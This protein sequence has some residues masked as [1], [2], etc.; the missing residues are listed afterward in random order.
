MT[1]HVFD[2]HVDTLLA[3]RN[4]DDFITGSASTQL[5]MPRAREAGVLTLVTAVCAEAAAENMMKAFAIGLDRF[6]I[7][8]G[9]DGL[10]I[11]LMLEGCEPLEHVEDRSSI[12][13][14]LAVASL[15]WNGENA[16]GG[17]IG[18]D[19]CLTEKGIVLAKE[20]H[21]NGVVLD[22]SHLCD[23]SR[24]QL[25]DT[26]LPVVATHCNCRAL[27]SDQRNLP[28]IDLKRI[29]ELGGVTGITLV[30]DFLGPSAD[31]NTVADHLEHAMVV[32]GDMHVGI[33]SDLDGTRDLPEG[34]HDCTFWPEFFEL[35]LIR[36]WKDSTIR[37][38]ADSNWRRVIP[39]AVQN[40]GGD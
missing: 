9:K 17:G 26:G 25:L 4:T 40:N 38:V 23:R 35:L 29:A 20:L 12:I 18:S 2:G 24:E 10:E 14:N 30:P 6:G 21:R 28:D 1:I 3:L 33:G 31:M 36:G 15:T 11:L 39:S 34:I 13:E 22:V 5:D 27:C 16:F 37:R 8:Q 32:A 7:L 19:K